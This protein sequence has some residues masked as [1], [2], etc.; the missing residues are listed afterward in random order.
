MKLKT[1][2]LLLFFSLYTGEVISETIAR[3]DFSVLTPDSKP[4]CFWYWMHGCISREGI[5]ADLQAMQN[6]GLEGAYLMPIRGKESHSTYEPALE[7]L[8]PEWWNMVRFAMDE[9]KKLNLKIAMHICD[10]FTLAGG[11]WITPDKS[12]QKVV[13]TETKVKGNKNYK[14]NLLQPE[15]KLGYYKDIAILA[16]P[17]P[18]DLD[19]NNVKPNKITSSDTISNL[20]FLVDENGKGTFRSEEPSWIIYEY[21]KPFL[22]R[23]IV[24]EVN[25]T[26]FQCHRFKVEASDDGIIYRFIAKLETPRHGWQ[27]TGANVTHAILPTKAK[28]FRFS[29]T[30]E[31]SAPGS[32]DM[33]NAKWK[34]TLKL[35]GLFLSAEPK[36]HQFEGKNASVW[37]LSP[38]T[39]EKQLPSGTC[40]PK[41][42]I[43]DLT[44]YMTSDGILNWK[45]PKGNWTI[46]R[47]G[48]TSTGI[49]NSTGG[50][51]AGLECD[52]LS[53]DAVQLQFDNWFGKA[54]EIAGPDLVSNVLKIMHIDSWECGSQNWS[55]TFAQEFEKRRGYSI[56]PY[57]PVMAGIPVCSAEKSEQVLFDVRQ[58]VSDLVN[59][60]FFQTLVNAAHAKG[61]EVTAESVAPT[62]MSD[63]MSHYKIVDFPMGE[64]WYDSPTHDKPNDM[65]DAISGGHVY[66]RNVIQAEAFT[67]LR[68][69]WN[70]TPATH[71]TL[72]DRNFA[73][74]INKLVFHV[75]VQNPFMD[76]K[77][78]MTLDGIGLFF[79]RDQTWWKPGRAWIDYITRCQTLLQIGHPVVDIAVFNGLDL[80]RRSML[81]DRLVPSL[82]GIFGTD[83]VASEKKRLENAGVPMT[84]SPVGV[85]HT[86]NLANAEDWVD[87]L[88]GYA[89]DTFNPDVLFRLA[90]AENGHLTL[91][92]G[93][94]YNLLVVPQIHPMSPDSI[95]P[96][97]EGETQLRN[98]LALLNKE[99]I[100]VL[101]PKQLAGDIKLKS[102]LPWN[103][104]DFSAMGLKRDF[105]VSENGKPAYGSVAWTHRADE[106]IDLYFI[107]N[108]KN[109]NRRLN[110]TLRVSGKVPEI[111][112][113]MTGV[114]TEVMNWIVKDG[115]TNMSID[116]EPNASLF[117]IFEYPT[118]ETIHKSVSDEPVVMECPGLQGP[119]SVQ[120]DTLYGG[121]AKPLVFNFLQS[122]TLNTNKA[123][124]YYSGTAVYSNNFKL[125]NSPEEGKIYMLDLGKVSNLAE[126]FVNGVS[127][128]VV[129]T[130]PYSIDVTRALKKGL[131]QLEISVTNTWAN[132]LELDALLP[133]KDR[134]TW[135]DGKYRKKTRELLD[136]GLSGPVKL[137]S[138]IKQSQRNTPQ[139]NDF[140]KK[141]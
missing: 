97:K 135:T 112:N 56:M 87:P 28:Y 133:E 58:T 136:A 61:C 46:L 74:G 54:C 35:T 78:G 131:N 42:S 52:K 68:N 109:K 121:P 106:D 57:L 34:P 91:P 63:G 103:D 86:A 105:E 15:T 67:Q 129:W 99:K 38:S 85:S 50:A 43:I 122:W 69:N 1:I 81:P 51:G 20:D 2:I 8:T 124:Q 25:G 90:K 88:R 138:E 48:H 130:E 127:C 132:R 134:L 113:P 82:P 44:R 80:P 73:L 12:M 55:K 11:P 45:A 75:F 60:I 4:W 23:S 62:M 47:I 29:W 102:Q 93:L 24:T 18:K 9:A 7:Q 117:V 14:I 36:I 110:V 17:T 27:N 125:D 120:F 39:T 141:D 77:P 41:E 32:E 37:R 19:I 84:E 116:F 83:R 100:P 96:N 118:N 59:D 66:G 123:V 140:I 13:W 40:I 65:L 6:I 16:Y 72:L 107:A 95:S 33:D 98:V 10:G 53:K 5:K 92:G 79:Q 119:W 94:S 71:K 128:G 111:Y 108:Q 104:E 76:R 26:V 31:G 70:E 137:K 101:L 89:Y 21:E 126:V 22:C 139:R 115:R 49:T 3:R 64:F 30:K 114:T